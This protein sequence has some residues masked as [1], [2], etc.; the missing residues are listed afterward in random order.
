MRVRARGNPHKAFTKEWADW[1]SR[2]LPWTAKKEGPECTCGHT[3][4]E[5][6]GC[7][8]YC[9]MKSCKCEGF[10]ERKK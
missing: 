2:E 7:G 8:H 4:G 1:M 10:T 6:C 9:F 5:H 3:Q